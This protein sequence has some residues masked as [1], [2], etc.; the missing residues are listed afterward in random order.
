M[1]GGEEV[2]LRELVSG[3]VVVVV[4]YAE[5]NDELV[6]RGSELKEKKLDPGEWVWSLG[7]AGV[8]CGSRRTQPL[9]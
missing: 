2:V 3:R 9:S 7:A 8:G 1:R 4:V 6:V 5:M